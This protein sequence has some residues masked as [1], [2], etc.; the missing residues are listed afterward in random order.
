MHAVPAILPLLLLKINIKNHK[1]TLG[2]F[3][4]QRHCSYTCQAAF[5]CCLYLYLLSLRPTHVQTEQ[6]ASQ[7]PHNLVFGFCGTLITLIAGQTKAAASNKEDSLQTQV[8]LWIV[9]NLRATSIKYANRLRDVI[10]F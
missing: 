10:T 3:Q 4:C 9:L 2:N 5:L 7:T 8:H 6:K 1:H